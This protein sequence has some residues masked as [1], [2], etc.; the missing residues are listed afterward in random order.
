LRLLVQ[1]AI[2]IPM[3]QH[4]LG[5]ICPLILVLITSGYGQS[6]TSASPGGKPSWT[7]TWSDEFNGPDGSLPD[8]DKWSLETGGDGWGNQELEYYTRRPDNVH[9]EDHHL[10]VIARREDYTG[11]DGIRRHFTSARMKSQGKFSQAY[12]RFEA[13]IRLPYG[14]G[15]WPAFWM[16][17]DNID[18]AGWPQCGEIDIM[19]NIGKE[20]STVHGTIHGPGYSGDNGIGAP[21]TLPSARFSDNY[22]LFAVEWAPNVIRFYVD[23]HLYA[24]RTPEE[25]PP[26]TSWVYNHPF[27]LILNVAV[28]GNWPGSPDSSTS[29]PQEM[30]VD[31]VRVYR[32]STR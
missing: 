22:H 2:E 32:P 20:S 6:T 26:G 18:Q 3:K 29:F 31:Y 19:E 21:F 27:F 9:I 14:Q 10:V 25:L 11:K 7:L 13:R 30:L 4:I 15:I 1:F 23:K 16:L 12:G 28:G 17:G 5:Q 24:T 8:A